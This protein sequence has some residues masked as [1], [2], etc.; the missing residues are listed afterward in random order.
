MQ[1]EEEEEAEARVENLKLTQIE[2]I[3]QY[4]VLISIATKFWEYEFQ[5]KCI[6]LDNV[7]Q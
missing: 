5:P 3:H 1:E 6:T 7:R 2:R 4:L